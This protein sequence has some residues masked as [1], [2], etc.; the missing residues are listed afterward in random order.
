MSKPTSRITQM[1][2]DVLLHAARGKTKKEIGGVLGLTESGVK[3]HLDA[4]RLQL[5][6][7]NTTHTVTRAAQL[8]LLFFTPNIILLT[9]EEHTFLRRIESRSYAAKVWWSNALLRGEAVRGLSGVNPLS[10]GDGIWLQG[11]VAN[12][13]AG[14]YRTEKSFDA[15]AAVART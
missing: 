11:T 8:G 10:H 2:L 7:D 4:L 14:A 13:L 3:F 9:V 12:H 15:A 6:S 1:Q 5:G